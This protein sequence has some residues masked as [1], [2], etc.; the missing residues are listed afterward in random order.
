LAKLL[1][2]L[3]IMERYKIIREIGDGTCGN[4]FMAYNVETNEIVAVKKMKRKFFQWEEC[5]SLREV[6]ALQKL[7]HPNIVKLKEVTMENHELF[8]IFEHMVGPLLLLPYRFCA[9][10]AEMI[11]GV[12]IIV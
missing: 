11:V 8:F 9:T 5:V 1:V 3:T 10:H 12:M 4:V 7:I 2:K 6:K